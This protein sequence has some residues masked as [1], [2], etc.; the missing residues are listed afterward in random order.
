MPFHP[1]KQIEHAV[2]SQAIHN[3]EEGV[4]RLKGGKHMGNPSAISASSPETFVVKKGA[5]CRD[6]I[7]TRAFY[8]EDTF[9]RLSCQRQGAMINQGVA[10]H[11]EKVS[12][13]FYGARNII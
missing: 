10:C 5:A 4:A 9:L 3:R 1:E 13:I 6:R 12:Q 8:T 11:R 2:N 7:R